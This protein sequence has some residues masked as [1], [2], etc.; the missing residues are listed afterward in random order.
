MVMGRPEPSSDSNE[1]LASQQQAALCAAKGQMFPFQCE[2]H[3]NHNKI[4]S[5]K[6]TLGFRVVAFVQHVPTKGAAL[7]PT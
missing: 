4:K 1:G 5:L 7:P 2:F 3:K 6:R